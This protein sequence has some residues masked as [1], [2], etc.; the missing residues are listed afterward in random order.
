MIDSGL[1]GSSQGLK[2]LMLRVEAF[3]S[4]GPKKFFTKHPATT[5]LA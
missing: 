5:A 2:V 3:G 4:E 1:G